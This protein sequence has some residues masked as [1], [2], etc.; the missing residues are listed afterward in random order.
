[1]SKSQVL[2][3]TVTMG[4]TPLIAAPNVVTQVTEV[5]PAKVSL[6]GSTQTATP[7]IVE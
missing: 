5:L 4:V 3:A 6:G 7:G 1:M 2:P